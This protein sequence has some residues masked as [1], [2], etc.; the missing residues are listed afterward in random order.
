MTQFI[1]ILSIDGGG[2]RGIL[3]AQFLANV[4]RRLR[5]ISGRPDACIADFFDFFA[6][7]STGGVITALHLTPHPDDPSR[8]KYDAADVQST[9]RRAGNLVFSSNLWKRLRTGGGF[10]NRKFDATEL[11]AAFSDYFHDTRLKELLKPCL[12][13][14]YDIQRGQ[15][16][17]FCQHMARMQPGHDFYVRDVARAT[18]AAPTFFEVAMTRNER[19]EEFPLIDGGVYAN[20]PA[21]CAYTEVRSIYRYVDPSR[22]LLLSVGTGRVPISMRYE[23]ARSFGI[24]RWLG[25][26][27]DIMISSVSATVQAHLGKL[28]DA[29]GCPD[30][31]LRINPIIG[32]T[33]LP[34]AEIDDAR[35]EN[36]N[37]LRE[38]GDSIFAE[39]G[40]ELDA[41][42]KR[43]VY[44]GLP[45]G[46]TVTN[47]PGMVR[48]W[49]RARQ[50][51]EGAA[52]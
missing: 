9:Y 1:R 23:A 38:L 28:F 30:Q 49:R 3:P 42:L 18:S 48:S 51:E 16:H 27:P 34:T 26:L 44:P 45:V 35:E 21:L 40:P 41:F 4:E 8:P 22:I 32:Q 14:A 2:I 31:Y 24:V 25:P 15:P 17:Y 33:P 5:E 50:A 6:G 37:A 47:L 39:G 10:L 46:R 43:L 36:I 13:T 19:G 52:E 11:E 12:L 7:T 20:D 29:A